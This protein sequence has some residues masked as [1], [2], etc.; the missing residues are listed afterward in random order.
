MTTIYLGGQQ[1]KY[2]KQCKWMTTSH[3][4]KPCCLKS[5]RNGEWPGTKSCWPSQASKQWIFIIYAHLLP[6]SPESKKDTY[7]NF[8]QDAM[9]AIYFML[10]YVCYCQSDKIL[11][12]KARPIVLE[13][14]SK[15]L[16]FCLLCFHDTLQDCVGRCYDWGRQCIMGK[17]GRC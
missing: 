2:Y 14:K 9:I 17:K 15:M 1:N 7:T 12:A 10:L 6:E 5:Q 16:N 11:C 3:L 8:I 13:D 4:A